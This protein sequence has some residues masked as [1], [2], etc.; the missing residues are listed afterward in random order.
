MLAAGLAAVRHSL[1][2]TG[3]AEDGIVAALRLG[4][5]RF[6][7]G[8][9]E[10]ND[11][12]SPR[13]TTASTT[14]FRGDDHD[15]LGAAGDM[16]CS[17]NASAQSLR[18][19]GAATP[20]HST[21]SLPSIADVPPLAYS[22]NAGSSEMH[23]S[24]CALEPMQSASVGALSAPFHK[25]RTEHPKARPPRRT[26]CSRLGWGAGVVLGLAAFFGGLHA[27]AHHG[28][29][30]PFP[31]RSWLRLEEAGTWTLA[32]GRPHDSPRMR[33]QWRAVR[34]PNLDRPNRLL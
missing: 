26:A 20:F 11:G 5:R 23:A 27:S 29:P 22:S 19:S 7:T 30:L 13:E 12:D 21:S 28:A 24:L 33:G 1:L 8:E 34:R 25:R 4:I 18:S 3:D 9:A 15:S 16:A 17:I 10:G 14:A 31:H 32:R 2:R 6:R